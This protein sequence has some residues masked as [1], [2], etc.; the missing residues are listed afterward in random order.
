MLI[1]FSPVFNGEGSAQ[2]QYDAFSNG[3][4]E[5]LPS[6]E[7]PICRHR[8]CL[9]IHGYYGRLVEVRGD[10]S[11]LRVT[12]LSCDMCGRTHALFGAG[13][14]PYSRFLSSECDEAA[15]E[16]G[17]FGQPILDFLARRL[18]LLRS[19]HRL[20]GIVVGK[21][22]PAEAARALLR[23]HNLCFLQSPGRPICHPLA[24][25]T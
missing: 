13:M 11:R 4:L 17:P 3:E 5:S 12:R 24:D 16:P 22:P 20:L 23:R 10:V 8:N 14:I 7:C 18:R 21:T 2:S 19:L 15:R 9:R 25:T 6:R 1:S